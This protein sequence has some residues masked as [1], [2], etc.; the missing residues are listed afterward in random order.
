MGKAKV[1]KEEGM[2]LVLANEKEE[3]KESFAAL[4]PQFLKEVPKFIGEECTEWMKAHGVKEPHHVNSWGAQFNALI[5]KSGQVAL[6]GR[7]RLCK[8]PKSHSHAT[9]EWM[10]LICSQPGRLVA[11]GSEYN[12]L[13]SDY[14][15]KKIT[16]MELIVAAGNAAVT[17]V[18]E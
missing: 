10:S 17:A 2:A 9:C 16:L 11:L 14:L 4:V 12:N 6:T 8:T 5:V 15:L 18:G 1:L 13:K 7:V 3:W